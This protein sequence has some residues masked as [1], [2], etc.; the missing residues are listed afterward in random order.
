MTEINKDEI[1]KA[2]DKLQAEHPCHLDYYPTTFESMENVN[3]LSHAIDMVAK[4]MDEDSE[5]NIICELAK[6]YLEGVRPTVEPK[7]GEWIRHI[8]SIECSVCKE[9]FFCS[10]K[11]E[12][13]QDYEP[14]NDF[15][16]NFCPNCGADMR[17]KDELNRVS[18]E[19]N[20]EIEY[21]AKVKELEDA[22]A[23][24]EKAEKDFKSRTC[25]F[26]SPTNCDFCSFHSDCDEHWKEGDEK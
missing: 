25:K 5:I 9:K 15:N 13:C 12:N 4:R 1:R 6:L 21:K 10:D 7:Q 11:E 8:L 20:S 18:K 17:V 26:R 19:L 2:I 22:I 23:K 24:C 16:F 14:C 3:S